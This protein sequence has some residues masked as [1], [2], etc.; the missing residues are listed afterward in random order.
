MPPPSLYFLVMF[1]GIIVI[2][3]I[4]YLIFRTG[5]RGP[6]NDSVVFYIVVGIVGL[7]LANLL[8]SWLTGAYVEALK[9]KM[10]FP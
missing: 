1:G 6:T 3:I 10:P 7:I 4:L 8:M 9:T 5:K 2:A